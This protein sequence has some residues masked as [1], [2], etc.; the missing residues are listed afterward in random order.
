MACLSE[1]HNIARRPV[2]LAEL[3]SCITDAAAGSLSPPQAAAM[4]LNKINGATAIQIVAAAIGAL[5][6]QAGRHR[7][8]AAAAIGKTLTEIEHRGEVA[9]AVIGKT[10]TETE[11]A[12]FKSKVE[13][14]EEVI[15]VLRARL[16]APGGPVP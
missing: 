11:L 3:E 7:E 4:V 1:N 16:A 14:F 6:V 9:S 10:L 15:G 2:L 8:A 13:I 5:R 12:E